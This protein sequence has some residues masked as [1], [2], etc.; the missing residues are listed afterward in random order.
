MLIELE[1]KHMFKI[2]GRPNC[3]YCD[4]AKEYLKNKGEQ[5]TYTDILAVPEAFEM[6]KEKGLKTVP[7]I[8]KG[9]HHIGGYEELIKTC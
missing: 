6:F 9:E 7:Q 1:E 5:Y 8:F 4:S 3:S 2:Y